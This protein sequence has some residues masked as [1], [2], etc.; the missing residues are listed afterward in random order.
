MPAY[1][2][3][4]SAAAFGMIN[5]NRLGGV[6]DDGMM[7]CKQVICNTRVAM[8]RRARPRLRASVQNKLAHAVDA[9]YSCLLANI[10]T[11]NK[12]AISLGDEVLRT[13]ASCQALTPLDC[14]WLQI[15]I[16]SDNRQLAR[17][18]NESHH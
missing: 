13:L 12:L 3:I 10:Y 4:V 17:Y 16:M 11:F 6:N 8:P 5:E 18:P 1:N 14:D 7:I 15:Y 9:T 2:S